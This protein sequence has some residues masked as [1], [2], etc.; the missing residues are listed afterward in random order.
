MGFYQCPG[1][2]RRLQCEIKCKKQPSW[3]TLDQNLQLETGSCNF[4][5]ANFELETDSDML[6]IA[7]GLGCIA[8]PTGEDVTT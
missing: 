8:K 4:T 1:R 7:F 3:L 6:P 2:L 5:L